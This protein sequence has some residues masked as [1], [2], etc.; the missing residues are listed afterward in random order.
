MSEDQVTPIL[1]YFGV[2]SLLMQL[3]PVL[4]VEKALL[5]PLDCLTDFIGH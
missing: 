1:K 3:V 4:L 2:C 5:S